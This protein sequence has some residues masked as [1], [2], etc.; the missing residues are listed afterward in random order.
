MTC[1]TWYRSSPFI[2]YFWNLVSATAADLRAH[3][4]ASYPSILDDGVDNGGA[5]RSWDAYLSPVHVACEW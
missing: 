3:Q 5:R 2:A 1:F 4:R